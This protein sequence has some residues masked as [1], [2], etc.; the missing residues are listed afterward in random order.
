MAHDDNCSGSTPIS[1]DINNIIR[2]ENFNRIGKIN[3]KIIKHFRM[4]LPAGAHSDNNRTM[5]EIRWKM[6]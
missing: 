6:H 1:I 2:I 5:N 3:R 4:E